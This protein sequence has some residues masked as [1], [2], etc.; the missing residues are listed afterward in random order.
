MNRHRLKKQTSSIALKW[1][2]SIVQCSFLLRFRRILMRFVPFLQLQSQVKNIAYLSWLVDIEQVRSRYP[3]HVQLWEKQGKTIFT[4]L[5]YQHQHFGFSFLGRLRQFMPS[6]QQSNWRFYVA[7]EQ[8]DKTVIFEQV[9]IDQKFYV[10][11]GRLASDAMPAQYAQQFV[12]ERQGDI[13]LTQIEL[14]TLYRLSSLVQINADQQLPQAWKTLFDSWEEAITYLVDQDHAW[15]EWVDQPERLSQG[16]IEMPFDLNQIQ[17]AQVS[18][19]DCPLL[20]QWGVRE[21]DVF[22]FVVPELNFYVKNETSLD[23]NT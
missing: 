10:L 1:I 11:S 21:Q 8:Q 6:P 3:N 20:R 23:E 9:M 7:P 12:H 19:I 13:I 14:D 2:A 5:T 22:A 16:D 4:I 15:V 17:A 18:N